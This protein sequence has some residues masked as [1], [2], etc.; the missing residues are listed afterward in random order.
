MKTFKVYKDSSYINKNIYLTKNKLSKK[1]RTTFNLKTE[2]DQFKGDYNGQMSR[3][4]R[5]HG[6]EPG[7]L[8][9]KVTLVNT[10][11]L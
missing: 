9:R 10:L 8:L 1:N 4:H 6:Y 11:T 7:S 5:N 3:T 2:N